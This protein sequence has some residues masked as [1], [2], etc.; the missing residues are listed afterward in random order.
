M[1]KLYSILRKK[2]AA[3]AVLLLL[4]TTTTFA[5]TD[6]LV[7]GACSPQTWLDDV[8]NKLIATGAFNSVATYN[9]YLTGTPTLAYM[10]GFDAILVFTDYSPVDPTTLGNNLAQYIDGGGGVVNSTFSN[11]SVLIGGNFNTTPYQV[12]VPIGGQYGSPQLQLGTILDPCH[13]IIQGITT[14]DGGSSSYRS[15]SNTL[16]PGASFVANWSNNDWLVAQRINV[17]PMNVRRADLNFYPPS[18]TVRSDFWDATTQGGQLMANALLWVAGV[19]NAVGLPPTPGAITGTT[20]ICEGTTTGFSIAAVPGA[21][22]YT[23]AAPVGTI[24]QSGQ[25]TTSVVVLAGN[26]S[27][28]IT[29]TADNAC[30]SSA[31]STF[32][33]TISPA[34]PVSSTSSPAS[35]VCPGG[36]VTLSGTGAV[37]YTWSGGIMDAVAF[38]PSSTT[39]YTV[40]G[41]DG[42]GCTNT[43]THLVT[44]YPLPPVVANATSLAVCTGSP[45]TLSGSGATSYIWSGAVTDN[46]AFTPTAT[47]TYTVTGI[48]ANGCVNTDSIT[49]TLNP[50][51]AVVANSTALAVCP[52]SQVTLSGSGASTYTWTGSVVD[53][54]AF[55]PTVTATYTVTGTDANGCVNTDAITVSLNTIPTVVANTTASA[56]CSGFPV[57][58]SGSGASTYTWT[59]SVTDNVA[60]VPAATAT[61]TVTG[62]DANGCMNTAAITVVV[63]PSPTIIGYTPTP[64]VCPGSSVTLTGYGATSYTWTGGVIDG[65]PFTAT[66]TATYTVTGTDDNGCTNTDVVTITVI[67]APTVTGSAATTVMCI[68]DANTTLFG[69][70]AGGMWL[71][72]GAQAS[73]FNPA[74]GGLG[75]DVVTYY[76]TDA[77]SGCTGS[78]SVTIT[79][80][81]CV[82]VVENSLENG[83]NIYPNPNNGEFTI[84]IDANVGD[85]KIEILDMQGRVIYLSQEN[86]VQA[87]FTSRV[88]LNEMANGI[89]MV[90]LTSASAQRMIKVAVQE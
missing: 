87:G 49:I 76:Y 65:V 3:A 57:T 31:P 39:T 69:S 81:A 22:S 11:A 38:V 84:A 53:N 80:N 30:G 88:S 4:A 6:V 58:L 35:A 14:F 79:V 60:F 37:S 55:T 86:N 15:N 20:P 85:L 9:T 12:I 8:Q 62:T 71:G 44:V 73:T 54:V 75:Q 68:D 17:G 67:P 32:T 59:G 33:L 36:S 74:I 52:G 48:D 1:K 50:L 25:G 2:I 23:W 45:V 21:T 27:G 90:R 7:C 24:I 46:V 77:A 82:G 51:P 70:P 63:N 40:T 78:A 66:T 89:Y 56:V 28:N 83:V 19:T 16:A 64:S 72:A 42:N 61:Y 34:P 18:S 13:P 29:V 47:D 43:A 10:Q 26:T 5:Q 41:T